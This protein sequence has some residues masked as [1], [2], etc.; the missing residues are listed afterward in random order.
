MRKLV[1]MALFLLLGVSAALAQAN[2]TLLF[3]RI[4]PGARQASMGD[5]GVAM[6]DDAYAMFFNPAGLAFQYDP[7]DENAKK[8]EASLT[9]AQWLPGFNFNDIYYWYGAGRYYIDGWGMFGVSV[10]FFNYGKIA[11]TDDDGN[12]LGDFTANETAFSLAYSVLLSEKLSVGVTGKFIYSNLAPASVEV[13]AQEGDG[14]VSTVALDL[15]VLYKQGMLSYGLSISNMGPNVTYYNE[16]QADPMPTVLRAGIAFT[17]IANNFHKLTFT[18]EV[19][20]EL[21]KR[22]ADGGADQFPKSLFTTWTNEDNFGL[23]TH[24]IGAEYWYADMVAVRSG[25]FYEDANHGDRRFFS[26]GMGLRYLE[27][28]GLEFSYIYAVKDFDP[29]SDTM[30]FSMLFD[31]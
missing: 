11:H 23:F 9:Y 21:T 3:L 16:E 12:P 27:Y 17:P 30:R 8:G 4:N 25:Y 13:G 31:F 2:S 18:Y 26:L 6:A 20:R 24:G 7:E 15:G 29:L 1:V 14:Q 10:Q 5:A 22:D 19:D 28:L